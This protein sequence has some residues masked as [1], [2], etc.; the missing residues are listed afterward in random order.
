MAGGEKLGGGDGGGEWGLDQGFW[1]DLENL[2]SNF[3]KSWKD[4]G[5]EFDET[6]APRTKFDYD[7]SRIEDEREKVEEKAEGGGEAK[8][9]KSGERKEKEERA[10]EKLKGEKSGVW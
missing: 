7:P 8:G 4:M 2:E 9:E 3:R 6:G 10:K 1:D 5:G